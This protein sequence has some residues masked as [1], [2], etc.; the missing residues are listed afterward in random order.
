MD[1]QAITSDDQFESLLGRSEKRP[2]LLMKFSPICPTS[3]QIKF[4]F[5]KVAAEL[6][7]KADL[8]QIDVVAERGLTRKISGEVKVRHESPQAL[9]LYKEKVVWH[10]SHYDV[11]GDRLVKAVSKF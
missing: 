9:L 2:Q 11:R 6:V 5:E 10:A 1:I 7:E 3:H 4:E 8:Y